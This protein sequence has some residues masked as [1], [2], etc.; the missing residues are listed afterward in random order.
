M[1]QS[2]REGV[3][4]SRNAVVEEECSK[5]NHSGL[6]GIPRYRMKTASA[7]LPTAL[8]SA[9][10]AIRASCSDSEFAQALN[11]ALPPESLTRGVYS[12]ETLRVRF[13]LSRNW[14]AG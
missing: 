11:A 12:E 4:L 13:M 8:G 2:S 7:D 1:T 5:H 6:V 10:E 9:V 14:P 3:C